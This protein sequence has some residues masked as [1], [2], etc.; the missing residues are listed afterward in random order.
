MDGVGVGVRGTGSVET[1]VAGW[2]VNGVLPGG[3]RVAISSLRCD[4]HAITPRDISTNAPKSALSVAV[5]FSHD[6]DVVL[7]TQSGTLRHADVTV[8]HL[9]RLLQYRTGVANADMLNIVFLRIRE[10]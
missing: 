1:G 4:P 3:V 2:E 5:T 7:E 10:I 8:L 9:V 6:V